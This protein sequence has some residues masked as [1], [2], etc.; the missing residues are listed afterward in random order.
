MTA[1]SVPE[2]TQPGTRVYCA[3]W[4]LPIT[5]EPVSG[6]AVAVAGGVIK[7][8]GAAAEVRGAHPEAEVV[9]FHDAIILPGFVNCH[10]HLEYAVF[11]GLLDNKNF[12]PWILDFIDYKR[13]LAPDDYLASA[14]LGASECAAAGI[15]TIADTMHSGRSLAAIREAGLRG[16]V[17][18]EVL[19]ID[20][21]RLAGTVSELKE[22]LDEL[23]EQED[24]MV[25]VGIFPH[26]TYTV[27]ANLYNAV[28]HLARERGKKVATHLA[29]S[30][31]ES[32]YIKSGSGV[33]ALDFREKVGWENIISEPFG[34]TP[35]KYLQQ[36]DVYGTDFMAVHSPRS[37]WR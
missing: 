25:E 37:R 23:Q 30:R 11:R 31:E 22:K 35:V 3:E 12:G 36:W 4:V 10:S 17:Y 24:G 7:A 29:E 21:S 5:S 28:S 14:M 15:T 1:G 26:A 19:G 16:R 33:L 20:D 9:E 8:V 18:H 34:V 32:T 6:G 2:E 27:S 13:R